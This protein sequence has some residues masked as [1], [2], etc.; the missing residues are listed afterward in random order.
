MQEG[1]IADVFAVLYDHVVM[2]GTHASFGG[3]KVGCGQLLEPFHHHALTTEAGPQVGVAHGHLR[4]GE[5]ATASVFVHGLHP[6]LAV[7]KVGHLVDVEEGDAV[8]DGVPVQIVDVVD[9]AV[10]ADGA[11][12]NP[13]AAD[14]HG[15]GC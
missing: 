4:E 7:S 9:C 3:I 15:E 6:Y 8:G 13:A 10:D 14:A 2:D 12:D 11:V 5:D 1:D